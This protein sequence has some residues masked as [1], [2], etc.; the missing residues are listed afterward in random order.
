MTVKRM[1]GGAHSMK[2]YGPDMTPKIKD[3][4]LAEIAA[5]NEAKTLAD[6]ERESVSGPDR[7]A[8]DDWVGSSGEESPNANPDLLSEDDVINFSKPELGEQYADGKAAIDEV[9]SPR[10]LQ[11]WRLVMRHGMTHK[12]AGSLL[13]VSARTIEE[14]LSRAT[15]KVRRYLGG[16]NVNKD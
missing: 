1:L 4:L 9:L 16:S 14:Y 11:V 13:H 8:Y 15:E 6:I 3:E 12:Q 7:N 5:F 10:Q 2:T